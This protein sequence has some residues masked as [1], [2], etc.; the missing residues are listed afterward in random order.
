VQYPRD[1]NAYSQEIKLES[2]DVAQICRHSM[3]Y[4]FHSAE[5]ENCPGELEL[6]IFMG[7]VANIRFFILRSAC[8][9]DFIRYNTGSL[10]CR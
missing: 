1:H 3:P 5:S 10:G 2:F 6:G 4:I 9:A 8:R 7:I